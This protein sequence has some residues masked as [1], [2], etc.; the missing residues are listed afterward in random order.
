[1]CDLWG[2][3]STYLASSPGPEKRAW[4][5]LTV[6]ASVYTQNPGKGP[7]DEAKYII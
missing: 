5:T 6:H 4:Y 3:Y 1:M 7:G 2:E